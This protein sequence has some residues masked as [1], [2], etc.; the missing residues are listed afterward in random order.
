MFLG[1]LNGTT[2]TGYTN[3]Y[4]Y[5]LLDVIKSGITET[6][7]IDRATPN[8][9]SLSGGEI[10]RVNLACSLAICEYLQVPF[11]F[12]DE[13]TS[14]LDN[15]TSDLIVNGIQEISKDKT[16]LMIAHQPTSADWMRLQGAFKCIEI[17]PFRRM[18][19]DRHRFE[20]PVFKGL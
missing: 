14:N 18:C 4:T 6:L 5:K 12:L 13:C 19:S 15:I 16:I 2:V 7:V 9:S 8:L 11:I 10:Q 17:N 20:P 3:S 1:G